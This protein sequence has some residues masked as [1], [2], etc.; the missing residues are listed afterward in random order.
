MI[1]KD[2]IY[3]EIKIDDPLVIEIINTNEFLR[4]KKIDVAGYKPLYEPKDITI[5][6]FDHSRYTHSI[7]VYM[8]LNMY[9]ASTEEQIAGLLHDISHSA[10]SHCVDYALSNGDEKKH[11]HQDN[12]HDEYIK[13]TTIPSILKK[14]KIDIEYI[15]NDK[16]FLLK[17]TELPDLCADRIDYSLRA[18]AIFHE[19]SNIEI[20][21]II[22][23]LIVLNEKWALKNQKIAK[24]YANLFKKLNDRF[25]SDIYS[26]AMFAIVGD[27]LKHAMK[28]KYIK[29]KELW[30]NDEQVIKKINI[31]LEK[32]SE[33]RD[34]WKLMNKEL[35]YSNN[36]LKYNRHVYCKNRL[37][38]PLFLKNGKLIRLSLSDKEWKKLF[39]NPVTPKEYFIQYNI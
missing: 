12:I 1:Y 39:S 2:I 26:G 34:Y 25:W 29:E 27:Y 4:L 32:D 15:L 8:L 3:G 20:K 35:Q 16:N 5:N 28:K 18:A 7:G 6:S 11:S 10:F 31:N 14:Y 37:I 30:M 13:N 33:L 21:D 17:E 36:P 19:A 38:D 22:D 24:I 23:N 9:N